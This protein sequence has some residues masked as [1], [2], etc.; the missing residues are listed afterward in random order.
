MF[1]RGSGGARQCSAAA[2]GRGAPHPEHDLGA[3]AGRAVRV[4]RAGA[5]AEPRANP[6]LRVALVVHP[7]PHLDVAELVEGIVVE[8]LA[9][10]VGGIMLSV[11]AV[12]A[13][14]PTHSTIHSTS[15]TAVLVLDGC[16][17]T[18]IV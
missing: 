10:G 1:E 17:S 16:A 4:P 12:D 5:D 3:V 9:Q 8:H 15:S 18:I 2:D 6:A 14:N 11:L 7:L 13:T